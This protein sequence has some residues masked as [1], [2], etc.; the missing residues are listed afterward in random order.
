MEIQKENYAETRRIAKEFYKAIGRLWCPSLNDYIFFNKHGFRH[1][2]EKKG[3]ARPKTEQM[4]RFVMLYYVKDILTS[5]GIIPSHSVKEDRNSK[6]DLWIF[7]ARKDGLLIKII[8][9]HVKGGKK[10][11]LSV[12]GRTQKSTP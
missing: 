10:Q 2:I 8:I 9:R 3:F 11:F 5:P 7:T 6:M 1:L 4:R 12:Y